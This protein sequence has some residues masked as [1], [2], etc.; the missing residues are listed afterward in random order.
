MMWSYKP[1][2][3]YNV[4]NA[5]W[6]TDEEEEQEQEEDSEEE[7]DMKAEKGKQTSKLLNK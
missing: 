5:M 6:R 4:Y 7:E 3:I 1:C 2:K